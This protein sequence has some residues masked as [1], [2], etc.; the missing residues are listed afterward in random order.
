M[1]KYIHIVEQIVACRYPDTDK[2][3]TTK[4]F[5][6]AL[7]TFAQ[8]TFNDMLALIMFLN[9]VLFFCL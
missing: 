6:R 7:R 9:C 2:V 4:S 5:L 3:I 8:S 1:V